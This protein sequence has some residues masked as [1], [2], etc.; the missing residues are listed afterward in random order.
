MFIVLHI[1]IACHLLV[2][3]FSLFMLAQIV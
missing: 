3:P 2:F 1:F